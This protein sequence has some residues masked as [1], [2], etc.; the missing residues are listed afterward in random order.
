MEPDKVW[1]EA[2][3][4]LDQAADPH[5]MDTMDCAFTGQP[6]DGC[7]YVYAQVGWLDEAAGQAYGLRLPDH[8]YHSKVSLRVLYICL[9]KKRGQT[10]DP[11]ECQ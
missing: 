2:V 4:T 8:L 9:G 5:A 10:A 7:G 11:E 1:T 6:M 3:T